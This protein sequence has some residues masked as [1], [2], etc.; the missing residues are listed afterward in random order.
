METV[1]AEYKGVARISLTE[2]DTLTVP[3]IAAGSVVE[4][5]GALYYFDEDEGISGTAAAGNNYI[6]LITTS[7]SNDS[8]YVYAQWSQTA[9]TWRD[10][11]QGWYGTGAYVN[12]VY[13]PFIVFKDGGNYSKYWMVLKDLNQP[14]KIDCYD[15]ETSGI[16]VASVEADTNS[17]EYYNFYLKKPCQCFLMWDQTAIG[18]SATTTDRGIKLETYQYSDYRLLHEYEVTWIDETGPGGAGAK[19]LYAVNL[20]PGRYRI[21]AT[22]WYS[23]GPEV[24]TAYLYVTG[25]YGLA[26]LDDVNVSD[27]T[28]AV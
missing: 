2:F 3:Q 19:V 8:S 15:I 18:G 27:I 22:G 16:I 28:E 10:D 6:I 13:L 11:A 26:N 7:D 5:N 4:C 21:G 20:L 17:F 9:P 14:D 25:I 24:I 23:G 12:C 1:N